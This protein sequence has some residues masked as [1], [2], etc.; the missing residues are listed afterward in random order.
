VFLCGVERS[1]QLP[2]N[3]SDLKVFS[4]I[5][6]MAVNTYGDSDVISMP[7]GF[8]AILINVFHCDISEIRVVGKLMIIRTFS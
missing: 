5:A 7:A 6:N 1:K 4:V 3:L 8:S 2:V